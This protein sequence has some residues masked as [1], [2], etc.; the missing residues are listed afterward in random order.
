MVSKWAIT[1]FLPHLSVGEITQLPIIDP[2]FLGHPFVPITAFWCPPAARSLGLPSFSQAAVS[3]AV[4][5][6]TGSR[7]ARGLPSAEEVVATIHGPLN[8]AR[9]G[10]SRWGLDGNR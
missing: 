7:E 8:G 4:R 5:M 2:N 6:A 3:G 9:W 10:G 1:L